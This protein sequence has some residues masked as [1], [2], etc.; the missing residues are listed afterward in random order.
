MNLS[1]A[2]ALVRFWE[3]QRTP[4]GKPLL[5]GVWAIFGHG[6]VGGLGRAL[7]DSTL[8]VLRA[9]HETAMGLAAVAFAKTSRR[10]R[11]MACTTS[12]GPGAT[13]LVTAAAAARISRLPILLWVGD[14]FA[15][16][17]PDPVLQ[18]LEDPRDPSVTVNEGLRPV[19]VYYD[20][21]QRPEQLPEALAAALRVLMDPVRTGPVTLSLPQD[22]QVERHDFPSSLFEERV[23]R[24]RRPQPDPLEVEEAAAV[25]RRARRPLVVVGGGARYAEAGPRLTRWSESSGLLLAET[26]AGRGTVVHSQMLGGIGVTGSEPANRHAGQADVIIS[27]GSRLTD[28][29]TGS[30]RLF[31]G[32]RLV[33]INVDPFDAA[34]RNG[35]PVVGDADVGVQALMEA[36]KDYRAPRAWT[37]AGVS[38]AA[39]WK[40]RFVPSDGPWGDGD[41][42]LALRAWSDPAVTVVAASGGIPGELHKLWCARD[43]E[44]YHVEY[45]FSCMG[46][47]IAGGV[48][49]KLARPD[50]SVVVLV[51]DGAYL[52][53]NSE[54]QTAASSNIDLTVVVLDNRGFGCIH[55]LQ[56]SLGGRPYN[57]LRTGA[58]DFV[59]HA[60]ALGAAARR[61]TPQTFHDDLGRARREGGV[62]VLVIETDPERSTTA[63]GFP[64]W[65]PSLSGEP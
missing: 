45:G 65:V 16:R 62:Q 47:E 32:A 34:K 9:H 6:N 31:P 60:Q 7:Q 1:T 64:W 57:N 40:A 30:G 5:G 2:T 29:T 19:S 28:F 56:S 36:T 14:T 53:L 48:G 37:E 26:H 55:R 41:V 21:I 42:V 13:N 50:R 15:T 49:V 10:R 22:V 18:Q 25:L 33:S 38:S 61:T 58:V 24:P 44:D 52:M 12:I 4:D 63:G 17:G 35:L 23:W 43:P 59:A 8:G 3:A 54:L 27:V 20:R 51:G 39:E 46:Y 11:F